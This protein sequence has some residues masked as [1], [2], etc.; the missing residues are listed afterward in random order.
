MVS[1]RLPPRLSRRGFV[2]RIGRAVEAR[3]GF[4]AGKIG[5]SEKYILYQPIL[6][7]RFPEPRQRRAAE[8]VLGFHGEV[9]S[10]VFPRDPGFYRTFLEAYAP[11]LRELD[12]LGLFGALIEPEILSHFGLTMDVMHFLDQEPGRA[13]PD[14]PEA[15]YLRHFRD[16]RVLLISPFA[17][18]MAE[19]AD[20]ATF[21]AVWAKTGKAWFHPA[22]V[23]A[24]TMPYGWSKQ[25]Q[26]RHGDSL[27]LLEHL[28]SQ[29]DALDFDVALISA[30]G[31][32]IPLAVHAKRRGAVGL[33]LG[34]HL[35]VVF[36]LI[37]KRWR[38]R[39][40]WRR[41]YFTP[42]WTDVPEASVPSEAVLVDDGAY[43]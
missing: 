27:A 12:A 16:K 32:G 22:Q 43:W 7:R 29:M 25:T 1:D 30:G 4:A 21:E 19:R 13:I 31:L 39:E 38:D 23:L 10:G 6:R 20:A 33:S 17:Q 11:E 2:D 18:A 3:Q 34:G 15:C 37:G 9:Q 40:D 26:L 24:L 41:D 14:E 28:K 8:L 5:G 36:G 35:Q 42:A